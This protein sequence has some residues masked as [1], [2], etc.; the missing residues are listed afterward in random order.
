MKRFR[1]LSFLL[2][3]FCFAAFF[4]A[5][6]KDM[7]TPDV[8]LD[9]PDLGSARVLVQGNLSGA[10]GHQVS[11]RVTILESNGMK[12]LRFENFASSNGP[13]LKVY[14]SQDAAATRFINLGQLKSISGNQ[15]YAISGMPDLAAYPYAL[16]WCEQFGV[17]FGSANLK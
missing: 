16:I 10:G 6:S 9:D 1:N 8:P 5:C 14:L 17:L 13:D 7:E 2:I 11:G 3:G 15:N 12:T 4:T